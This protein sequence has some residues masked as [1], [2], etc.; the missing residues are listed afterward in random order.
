MQ[1]DVTPNEPSTEKTVIPVKMI[2]LALIFSCLV[3]LVFVFTPE[4]TKTILTSL[5]LQFKG[6]T[7]TGVVSEA[8]AVPDGNPIYGRFKYQL[9]VDFDADGKTYSVVSQMHYAPLDHDW[10]GEPVEV[11]YNPADPSAALINSFN[12]RWMFP[13]AEVLPK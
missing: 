8:K 13:L 11:I 10:V 4:S 9:T 3:S 5:T 6:V 2:I 12:E 1:S 7:T